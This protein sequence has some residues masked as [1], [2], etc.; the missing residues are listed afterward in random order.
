MDLLR[1][2]TSIEITFTDGSITRG[3]ATVYIGPVPEPCEKPQQS[4]V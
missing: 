2:A 4:G 3:P 1:G